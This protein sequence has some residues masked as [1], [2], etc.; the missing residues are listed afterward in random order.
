MIVFFTV[1]REAIPDK[2]QLNYGHCIK[3]GKGGGEGE[4]GS[5]GEIGLHIAI[6]DKQLSFSLNWPLRQ[7]SL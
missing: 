7:F 1:L 3:R 2:N 4:G 6:F 5:G